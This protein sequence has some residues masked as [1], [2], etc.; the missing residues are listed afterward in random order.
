MRV[1]EIGL[2]TWSQATWIKVSFFSS[3]MTQTTA[4]EGLTS[5]KEEKAPIK[6][7]SLEIAQYVILSSFRFLTLLS[8]SLSPQLL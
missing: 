1:F 8:T 5:L 2:A 4:L 3:T 7:G 6:T